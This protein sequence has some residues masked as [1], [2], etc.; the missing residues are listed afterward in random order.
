MFMKQTDSPFCR[1]LSFVGMFLLIIQLQVMA[2]SSCRTEV[3]SFG[4]E[5]AGHSTNDHSCC[6]SREHSGT[7]PQATCENCRSCL[8]CSSEQSSANQ[9][10]TSIR[11]LEHIGDYRIPN[12]FHWQLPDM[13]MD[14][15]KCIDSDLT[16]SFELPPST[17]VLRI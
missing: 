2:L 1:T 16:I 4:S 5:V 17:P 11:S 7:S 14:D 6:V 13:A 9:S 3:A 12:A 8:A 15:H 10:V